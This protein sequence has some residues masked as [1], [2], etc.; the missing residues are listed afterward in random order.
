M[1]VHID[2]PDLKSHGNAVFGPKAQDGAKS[3]TISI[4]VDQTNLVIPI[5]VKIE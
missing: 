2:H 5:Q 1:D 4:Q 3:G